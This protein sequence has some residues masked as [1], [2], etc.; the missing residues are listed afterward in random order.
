M[1]L[2]PIKDISRP[3]Y[4]NY[5]NEVKEI[6]TNLANDYEVKF[7]GK[8]TQDWIQIGADH[9]LN[10][11]DLKK[12]IIQAIMDKK[13]KRRILRKSLYAITVLI[14]VIGAIITL[15]VKLM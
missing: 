6:I 8:S 10:P 3:E 1:K 12:F 14:W 15:V 9:N 7:S 11:Q 13:R 2:K 4:S 5:V